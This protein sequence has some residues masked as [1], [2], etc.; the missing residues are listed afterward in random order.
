[1]PRA[2]KSTQGHNLIYQELKKYQLFE[3]YRSYACRSFAATGATA[4]QVAEQAISQ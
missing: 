2:Q 1:M 3:S 4:P